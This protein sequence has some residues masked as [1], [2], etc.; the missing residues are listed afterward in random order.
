MPKLEFRTVFYTSPTHFCVFLFILFSLYCIQYNVFCSTFQ[1]IISSLYYQYVANMIIEFLISITFFLIFS[2]VLFQI[3]HVTFYNLLIV[4]F[5]VIIYFHQHISITVLKTGSNSWSLFG[6]ISSLCCLAGSCSL[7]AWLSWLE[8]WSLSL[9][10]SWGYSKAQFGCA[11]LQR[12]FIL[13]LLGT[14][15]QQQLRSCHA[16]FMA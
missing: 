13:V 11:P 7:E 3:G 14:W 9:D 10:Y 4:I 8:N 2:L 16:K 1:F 5:K 6:S 12:G 15:E